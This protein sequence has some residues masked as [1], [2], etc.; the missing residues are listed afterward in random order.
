[1]VKLALSLQAAL[2]MHLVLYLRG[3]AGH[4][5]R[6]NRGV[7]QC[8]TG[9]EMA[10]AEPLKPDPGHAGEGTGDLLSEGDVLA[11][12]LLNTDPALNQPGFPSVHLL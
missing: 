7:S 1:M 4:T 6:L 2:K 5:A 12:V 11:H 9:S 3:W 10:S 8:Y